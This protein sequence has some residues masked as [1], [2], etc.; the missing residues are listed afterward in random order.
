MKKAKKARPGQLRQWAIGQFKKNGIS[1]NEQVPNKTL[2]AA[3]KK[4]CGW[5]MK[6]STPKAVI[7]RFFIENPPLDLP[8]FPVDFFPK[9]PAP[10][11]KKK[12]EFVQTDKFLESFEWRRLRYEALK[13]N[14]G[15]CELCGRNK[16][17]GIILNVDHIKPRKKHPELALDIENLQ[18]LCGPCNHGKGNIDKTDWRQETV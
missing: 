11:K 14:D 12:L 6:N 10:K 3:I 8:K 16:H 5:N 4:L 2:A 13:K 17:D 1:I 18:V 9:A 7:K 15:R